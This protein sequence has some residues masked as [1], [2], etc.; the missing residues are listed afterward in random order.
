[1]LAARE[2]VLARELTKVHEE[3]LSG[4]PAELLEALARRPPIK[5]EI[6]LLVGKG[7]TAE[8]DAQPLESAVQQLMDAGVPRMEA[9]KIVARRRGLSKRAV[10]RQ[11]NER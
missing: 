3:F 9:L 2:V 1:M 5:G 6:T 8:P 10:Y 11:L 7:E 4:T